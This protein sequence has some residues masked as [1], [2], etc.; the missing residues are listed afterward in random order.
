MGALA[1]LSGAMGT[2][3]ATTGSA[4]KGTF[5]PGAMLD[6]DA[7]LS[8]LDHSM[9]S[10]ASGNPLRS[11]FPDDPRRPYAPL[12]KK[13]LRS[14]LIAGSFR[15]LPE[16]A[17]AHPGMQQRIRDAMPEMDEAVFG[18]THVLAS[19]TANERVRI[20]EVLNEDPE[21][22]MRIAES[23]DGDAVSA[24]VSAARR[25]HLRTLS[26]QI[27]FRLK[28]QPVTTL[29]DEYV[30]KVQKVSA[31]H[32]YT[33]EMQR[34]IA[35]RVVSGSLLGMPA[36][37]VIK[38]PPTE[39]FPPPPSETPPKVKT[40]DKKPLPGR[41]PI[42][43]GAVLMG[44]GPSIALTSFFLAPVAGGFALLFI[45]ITGGAVILLAGLVTLIAGLAI[46]A[47]AD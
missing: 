45:G 42:T 41:V 6:M 44:V 23:L 1:G 2:G 36:E 22:G 20:R 4:A 38:R 15:D 9:E 13:S 21:F 31:R 39:A 47:S 12:V 46:R 16:E 35:A 29:I 11:F 43:V 27:S 19:F 26:S 8:R 7:F 18:M 28:H 33:E 37:A 32:G 17:R 3:C 14:L 34:R 30:G 10:I 25:L 24:G 5:D 40:D